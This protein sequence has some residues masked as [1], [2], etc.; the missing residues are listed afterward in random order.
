MYLKELLSNPVVHYVHL[1]SSWSWP[2]WL[3]SSTDMLLISP[4]LCKGSMWNKHCELCLV[5]EKGWINT[6]CVQRHLRKGDFLTWMAGSA[7]CRMDA[8]TVAGC[9]H[10][11]TLKG[12][13]TLFVLQMMKLW[14][15]H[16]L[17]LLPRMW[18]RGGSAVANGEH[19]TTGTC[20]V[21][22][23][24]GLKESGHS[25]GYKHCAVKTK[26]LTGSH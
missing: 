14:P 11:G 9:S 7:S 19:I 16:R 4:L 24:D 1:Y 23:M 22:I 8:R 6:W 25:R 10:A 18:W 3:R 17:T 12:K 2:G 21:Q 5:R 15:G 26:L 13:I 20:G